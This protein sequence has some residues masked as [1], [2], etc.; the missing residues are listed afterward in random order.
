MRERVK[1]RE[2]ALQ[3]LYQ[4]DLRPTLDERDL[5]SFLNE[6]ATSTDMRDFAKEL[7]DGVLAH[8]RELDTLIQGAA[9]NWTLERMAAIDRNVLRLGAFELT[10]RRDI[11]VKVSIDC[12]V[13]LAKCF[14]AKD[15]GAFV[16]GILDRILSESE[17]A[18]EVE[19]K[20]TPQALKD[21]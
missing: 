12:A 6:Y 8:R 1:A 7:V 9:H 20:A 21:G 18:S 11:P 13:D 17:R 5:S 10:H 4:V 19:S 16:N 14:S 2:I 3:L 15:S